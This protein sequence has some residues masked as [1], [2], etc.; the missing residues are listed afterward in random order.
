MRLELDGTV[1]QRP[2]GPE[3]VLHD[4]PINWPSTAVQLPRV[5]DA[6]RQTGRMHV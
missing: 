2:E 5:W 1:P 6:T 4:L 3:N